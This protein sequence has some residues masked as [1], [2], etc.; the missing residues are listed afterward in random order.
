VVSAPNEYVKLDEKE[1]EVSHVIIKISQA[2]Q[3]DL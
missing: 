1:I 2:A 3:L